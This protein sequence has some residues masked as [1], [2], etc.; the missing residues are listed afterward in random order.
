MIGLEYLCSL[1][2]ISYSELA[3]KLGISKATVSNWIAGRRNINEKYYLDLTYIFNVPDEWF[4]KELSKTDELK[5]QKLYFDNKLA[6]KEFDIEPNNP[7]EK[8]RM[9]EFYIYKKELLNNINDFLEKDFKEYYESKG[10]AQWGAIFG[11]VNIILFTQLLEILEKDNLNKAV[12]GDVL[13]IMLYAHDNNGEK[14]I[15]KGDKNLEILKLIIEK[16]DEDWKE[17]LKNSKQD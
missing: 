11:Q 8:S 13:N 6:E 4:A 14:P 5:L 16:I 17:H 10:D 2:N 12:V 3:E 1:S 7:A 15:T 9:I